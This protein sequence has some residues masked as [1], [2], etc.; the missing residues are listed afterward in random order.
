[1]L[2]N[3]WIGFEL[4]TEWVE[5]IQGVSRGAAQKALDDAIAKG[6]LQTQGTDIFSTDLERWLNPPKPK[7]GKQPLVIDLLRE[8]FAGQPVPDPSHYPRKDLL[9]EMRGKH[10]TLASL[11]DDTLKKAIKR[12][13]TNPN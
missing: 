10:P 2:P 5:R 1:M 11:D 3:S 8:K 4:A 12:Y 13:N 6:L 7:V 9:A